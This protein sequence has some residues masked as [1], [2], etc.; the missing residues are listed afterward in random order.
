MVTYPNDVNK[1]KLLLTIQKVKRELRNEKLI[2]LF[3]LNS[4]FFRSEAYLENILSM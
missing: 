4:M 2:M 3:I 1:Y